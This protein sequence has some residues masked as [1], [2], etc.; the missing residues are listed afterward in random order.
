M[1]KVILTVGLPASGK[2]TWAREYQKENPNTVLIN[3][4]ELRSMLHSG[5]HSKG[6]EEFI[7]A[8]RDFIIK[9][10]VDEGH[11]VI[12]HDTN[13][14][15]KHKNQIWKVVADKATVETRDFT[16]VSVEECIK[17][18]AGRVGM[19]GAKVI[20]QMYRQYLRPE[21]PKIEV[22]LNLPSVIICDLDGTLALFGYANPYDRDFLADEVNEKVAD[23]LEAYRMSK[24]VKIILVSGRKDIFKDQTVA[25]LVSHGIPYDAL[26]MRRTLSPGVMEPKDVIVKQGIYES[27]IKGKYNVIFVLDDRDQVVEFW[28]SQ[29]LTCLQ[30]AEGDF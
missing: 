16:D 15:S 12:V 24:N 11:D 1:K 6:R 19:V 26:H 20:K 18:D 7:L 17:R 29:G 5:V 22:D 10:A 23:I 25:W 14:H 3:K 27:E 4:D 30:V 13:L 9:K 8:V 21:P 28:R 2:T